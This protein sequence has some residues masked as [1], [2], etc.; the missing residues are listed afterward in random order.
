MDKVLPHPCDIKK[1]PITKITY[2]ASDSLFDKIFP[3]NKNDYFK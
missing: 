2:V 3:P 1:K